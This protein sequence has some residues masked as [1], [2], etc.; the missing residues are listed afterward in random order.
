[1]VCDMQGLFVQLYELTGID[2]E[3]SHYT[4]AL[5]LILYD[6]MSLYLILSIYYDKSI[7]NGLPKSHP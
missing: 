7:H 1:M 5:L 4:H 3:F 2:E 6:C